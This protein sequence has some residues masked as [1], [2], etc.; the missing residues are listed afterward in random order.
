MSPKTNQL[1]NMAEE[2]VQQ[3]VQQPNPLD[4]FSSYTQDVLGVKPE[5]QEEPVKVAEETKQETV[6][7]AGDTTKPAET[8]TDTKIPEP[9]PPQEKSQ[10]WFDIA[11]F[12]EKFGVEVESEDDIREAIR[13]LTENQEY[14][15]KK[16]Y[17]IE[18]ERIVAEMQEHLNPIKVF[19]TKENYEKAMMANSLSQVMPE[20][21]AH[22]VLTTDLNKVDNLQAMYLE[23]IARDPNLL[24]YTTEDE[25]K[26][27]LL[28]R[29]NVDVT[30][31]EFDLAKYQDA[32]KSNPRALIDLSAGATQS[33][34]YF[35][36]LLDEARKVIPEIKDWNQ[37][38]EQRAQE[39]VASVQKRTSEW[40]EKAK[41]LAGQ[42]KE[43]T[44]VE[45]D[46]AGKDVID[47]TFPVPK[48]F[49]DSAA[50]YLVE[51][52]VS[53]GKDVTPE[54]VVALKA[55]MIDAFEDRYKVQIRKAYREDGVSKVKEDMDN[56]V[57]NN[58]PVST[59]EAPA[60]HAQT[61]QDE[62]DAQRKHFGLTD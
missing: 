23:A 34:N 29:A 42:F 61:Y 31:L 25:I 1:I 13:S 45:K 11:R 44:I 41:E 33:K 32:A 57:F 22:A 28:A 12:K 30:D 43:F 20:S 18:V 2:N 8:K 6:P 56:K 7:V 40:A 49:T 58:K 60:E 26:K 3:P 19:G 38:I 4:A 21:V 46:A 14:L 62:V 50:N 36:G 39:R 47:F 53:T 51:Y 59:Q 10:E 35:K 16:D 15:K 27:G 55:E 9:A 24:S 37:E 48:E 17:Y 5:K 54:M 52:A